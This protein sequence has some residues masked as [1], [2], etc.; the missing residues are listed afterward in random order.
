MNLIFS[1]YVTGNI[2]FLSLQICTLFKVAKSRKPFDKSKNDRVSDIAEIV[3]VN[4]RRRGNILK[5]KVSP[6]ND[7]RGVIVPHTASQ[8]QNKNSGHTCVM[9][10]STTDEKNSWVN[11]LL[12]VL[13]NPAPLLEISM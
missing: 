7:T 12:L 5:N 6:L 1:I 4:E 13:H 10:R 8:K 11:L 3:E 2:T 9:I